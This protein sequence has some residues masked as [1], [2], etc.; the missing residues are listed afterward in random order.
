MWYDMYPYVLIMYNTVHMILGLQ[1][2]K[3]R[4]CQSPASCCVLLYM[5]VHTRDA[6]VAQK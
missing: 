2:L 1:K 3:E 6:C 4:P 5:Y